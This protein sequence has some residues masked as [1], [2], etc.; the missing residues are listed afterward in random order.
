MS[1]SDALIGKVIVGRYR[2]ESLRSDSEAAVKVYAADDLR[3]NKK[4]SVRLMTT[5][6]LIDLDAGLIDESGALAAYKE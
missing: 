4:V 5:R 6:S 2:I 1:E 3:H